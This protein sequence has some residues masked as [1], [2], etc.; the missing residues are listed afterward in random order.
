MPAIPATWEVETGELQADRGQLEVSLRPYLK[1]QTKTKGLGGVAPMVEP[2][3]KVLVHSPVL[4]KQKSA[5]PIM[6]SQLKK[7]FLTSHLTMC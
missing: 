5:K 7:I 6:A 3:L 4:Q 2:L 1:K